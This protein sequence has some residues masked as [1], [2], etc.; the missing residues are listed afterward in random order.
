M[1]F[2][3]FLPKNLA[4]NWRFLLKLLLGFEKIDY[5]IGF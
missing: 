2:E 1:S 3:I 4:K 5:N